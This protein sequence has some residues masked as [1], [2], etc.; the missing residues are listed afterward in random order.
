MKCFAKATYTNNLNNLTPI[1]V[2]NLTNIKTHRIQYYSTFQPDPNIKLIQRS[3]KVKLLSNKSS[4]TQLI[5]YQ[6]TLLF[7]IVT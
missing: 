1:F 5:W 3:L 4:S 2:I 6:I 7:T